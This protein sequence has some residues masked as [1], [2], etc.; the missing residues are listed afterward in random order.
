LNISDAVSEAYSGASEGSSTLRDK[1]A[2]YFLY[3]LRIR[4]DLPLPITPIES[5]SA[6]LV[7]RFEEYIPRPAGPPPNSMKRSWQKQG[8]Q[9]VL[10]F[11]GIEGHVLEFVYNLEGT[12]VSI[13]QSYPEQRDTLFVLMCTALAAALH[14]RGRPVLHAASLV[15]NGAAYLLMGSS[16][17][18][19]STL[20]AALAAEGLSFHADDIAAIAWDAGRPFIQAGYPRLK[21]TP[22]VAAALGWPEDILLPIFVTIPD[23]PEKW[24]N[25]SFL[26]GG[27]YDGPAPLKAIY[28]LSGRAANLDVPRVETLSSSQSALAMVRHLYGQPWLRLSMAQVTAICTRLAETTPVRRLWLPD[29]LERLRSLSC[30]YE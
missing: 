8:N 27:F 3:G 25:A 4:S 19:K 11:Q 16:G 29:G 30:F 9:W 15:N 5:D 21:I 6:D 18:G 12:K 17:A 14:L 23:H 28:L 24:V 20:A 10:R 1:P 7:V 26:P 22:Q 2:T 13:R